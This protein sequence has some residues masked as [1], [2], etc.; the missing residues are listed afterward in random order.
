M[1]DKV[2]R[3][4]LKQK[5]AH[6]RKEESVT[7]KMTYPLPPYSTVIGAIH[8]ACS[9]TE[10]HPME[11]SI[12]GTYES[13][14]RE[15][16][17]DQAF[18]NSVMDDRGNLVK[19]VNPNAY[20]EGYQIIAKALKSQGNSFKKRITVDVVD[21]AAFEEYLRI[22][23]LR[24][25][26]AEEKKRVTEEIQ[27]LKT[28]MADRKNDLKNHKKGDAEYLTIQKQ[29]SSLKERVDTL[30]SEF[31][32]RKK[33]EYDD[34]IRYYASVTT[35]LRSYEVLYNVHLVLHIRT[36]EET[37][38]D[39]LDNIYNLTA[40]GR[41]E[42][43]VELISIELVDLV[44][45]EDD[46]DPYS[47]SHYPGYVDI[48]AINEEAV[49]Y[50]TESMDHQIPTQGTGFYLNKNYRIE[51]NQ[52][53]FS[54]YKVAYL[55]NYEIGDRVETYTRKFPNRY[56]CKDQDGYILSLL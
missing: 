8:N 28:E 38:Q 49:F 4:I 40:I 45:P 53:V 23:E 1:K 26:F 48:D 36:D 50:S 11:V 15:V 7:N 19:L 9:Y 20:N 31:K 25:F 37:T 3:I 10:Y 56:V 2:L 47:Q 39:I 17:R 5:K 14:N 30:D 42:D 18:L 21:E 22:S 29:I 32:E 33:T 54:R 24:E 41:S 43:F 44:T 52:R 27:P 35:S 34:P 13:M 51:K 12:Q 55:S 6:Y 46:K 16:Y